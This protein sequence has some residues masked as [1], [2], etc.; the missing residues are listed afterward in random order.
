MNLFLFYDSKDQPMALQ[1]VEKLRPEIEAS[2]IRVILPETLNTGKLLHEEVEQQMSNC[3]V[4][5]MMASAQVFTHP[6]YSII[7]PILLDRVNKNQIRFFPLLTRHCL[8]EQSSVSKLDVRAFPLQLKWLSE[9]SDSEKENSIEELAN[10]LIILSTE[11]AQPSNEI[12]QII[13]QLKE[14][15]GANNSDL[16]TLEK[17]SKELN[18]KEFW[19]TIPRS[20]LLYE[21][22]LLR[23]NLQNLVDNSEDSRPDL[24]SKSILYLYANPNG[25]S[26][27]LF[28]QEQKQI[29]D[30]IGVGK[31]ILFITRPQ[32][33][34]FE[35]LKEL[36]QNPSK[37]VHLSIHGSRHGELLFVDE[38][39]EAD[40]ITADRL[41]SIFEQLKAKNLLPEILLI[42]ACHSKGHAERLAELVPET[43]GMEGT[44][45]VTAAIKFAEIFYLNYVAGA[46]TQFA[47]NEAVLA[48]K[49]LNLADQR[50]IVVHEMP[51]LFNQKNNNYVQL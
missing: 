32:V 47:F 5:V 11:N 35:L 40:G 36:T 48:I 23:K 6:A 24:Y 21:Y 44:I 41:F 13:K 8:W 20:E 15:L 45:P 4:F 1:L 34:G 29:D 7:E 51:H 38:A 28:E 27:V 25:K 19:G 3:E 22:N 17:Q 49:K 12:K 33:E 37:I 39:H 9:G 26:P 50:G 18:K 31:E 14:Q 43:I 10:R 30:V 46:N 16:L 42:S 2:R